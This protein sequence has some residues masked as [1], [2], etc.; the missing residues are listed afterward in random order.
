MMDVCIKSTDDVDEAQSARSAIS[1][2]R[3][4]ADDFRWGAKQCPYQ[5]LFDYINTQSSRIQ[6]TLKSVLKAASVSAVFDSCQER[7]NGA[8]VLKP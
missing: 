4:L 7:Q 3:P 1:G 6:S 8:S 5:V 2:G